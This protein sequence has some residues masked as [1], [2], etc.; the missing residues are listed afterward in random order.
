[1]QW[2]ASSFVL[3]KQKQPEMASQFMRQTHTKLLVWIGPKLGKYIYDQSMCEHS[4]TL[5][6][7]QINSTHFSAS[8]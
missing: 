6:L 7:I 3:A 1:M 5:K 2:K 8:S 4:S